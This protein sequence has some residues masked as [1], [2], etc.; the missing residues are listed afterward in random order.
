MEI[1]RRPIETKEGSWGRGFN[2]PKFFQSSVFFEL[3]QIV[4]KYKLLIDSAK[5]L[6]REG[7]ISPSSF[8]GKL[9]DY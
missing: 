8:Y 3:E 1:L 4:K 2:S 6:E 7:S 5:I 9:L